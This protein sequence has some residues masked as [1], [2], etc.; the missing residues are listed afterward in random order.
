LI[1]SLQQKVDVLSDVLSL[2]IPE[3]LDY[4]DIAARAHAE[5]ALVAA[6]VATDLARA[7]RCTNAPR[8]G[9]WNEVRELAAAITNVIDS[10]PAVPAMSTPIE[11]HTA[12][13]PTAIG[14]WPFRKPSSMG[15]SPASTTTKNGTLPTRLRAAVAACRQSR[16]PLS[17]LLLAMDNHADYV[18]TQGL[19]EAEAVLRALHEECLALAVPGQSIHRLTDDRWACILPGVDRQEV[20]GMAARMVRT[21]AGRAGSADSAEP[22][23]AT[24]SAGAAAVDL[25]S[26]NFPAEELLDRA[27]SCLDAALQCGGNQAKTIGV[28]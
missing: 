27:A 26:K 6:D 21:F 14:A 4:R 22:W 3:D 12:P 1:E 17:L 18:F 2:P 11:P 13:H 5:L 7:G 10:G 25:P 23:P 15:P 20:A 28:Y 19:Q 8:P 16:R 24:A 9:E